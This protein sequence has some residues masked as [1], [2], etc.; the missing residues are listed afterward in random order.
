MAAKTRILA[1]C[2]ALDDDALT[3]VL[4]KTLQDRPEIAPDIVNMACPDLTYVPTVA[5]T[6]RRCSGT[7]KAMSGEFGAI[8]C[9]ELQ[10]VF[11]VDVIVN[12]KQVRSFKEGATVS[13]AV[14]L[15]AENE[16]QAFDLEAASSPAPAAGGAPDMAAMMAAMGAMGGGGGMNPMAA[17]MAAMGGGGGGSGND[18]AP[19]PAMNPMAAMMAAMGGGG[20]GGNDSAPAMNPMA[21]MMAAMGGGGGGASAAGSP[22]GQMMLQMRAMQAMGGI[23][24]IPGSSEPCRFWAKAGWC[25]F[26]DM[27]HFKHVGPANP[28]GKPPD[29]EIL[30]EYLGVIKSYNPEKGFGFIACDPLRAEYDGDVFLS[31][32]HVG[33]FQVGGEVKFTAYLFGGK[34]QCKDL[35]DATGQVGPQQGASNKGGGKAASAN[36]RE[37][38]TFVGMIK[39]YNTDKGFGFIDSPELKAQ[40]YDKDAFLSSDGYQGHEVGAIV[41]FTAYLRDSNLRARNLVSA[42][43]VDESGPPP[44]GP[45]PSMLSTMGGSSALDALMNDGG[46]GGLEDLGNPTKKQRGP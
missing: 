26:G 22:E 15:T 19:A 46:P 39:S 18:S 29:Q 25:K 1:M 32:K 42:N 33:D 11:G 9:S 6:N 27:C 12:R 13:F 44:P 5:L 31:Q 34:L 24:P 30:G 40:G 45:A 20:S 10:A 14:T 21:A 41:S 4:S 38:G 2:G 17:M 7:L 28:K 8:D 43:A 16:P 23:S 36:D 37:L 3:A 35:H